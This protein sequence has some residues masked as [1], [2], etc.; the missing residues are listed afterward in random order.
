M[1]QY[2]WTHD[3]NRVYPFEAMGSKLIAKFFVHGLLQLTSGIRARGLVGL[4]YG[5]L[6]CFVTLLAWIHGLEVKVKRT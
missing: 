6:C 1:V 4:S 5:C 3:A 2:V